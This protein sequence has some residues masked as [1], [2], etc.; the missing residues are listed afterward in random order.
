M[1]MM[2]GYIIESLCAGPEGAYY[3]IPHFTSGQYEK[4]LSDYNFSVVLF[5]QIFGR[6]SRK[7]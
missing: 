6:I 3:Y 5:G 7:C 2:G 4:A 1:L